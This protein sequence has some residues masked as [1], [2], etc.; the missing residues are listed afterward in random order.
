MVISVA[1][2]FGVEVGGNRRVHTARAIAATPPILARVSIPVCS[3]E[4][5]VAVGMGW[6]KIA[7]VMTCCWLMG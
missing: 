1:R 3:N 4:C 2:D 6:G 7:A 5:R